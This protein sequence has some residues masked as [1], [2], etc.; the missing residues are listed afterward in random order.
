MKIKILIVL[1]LS[2][3]LAQSTDIETLL[4]DLEQAEHN[5]AYIEYVYDL[6]EHPIDINKATKQ[7]LES[8]PGVSPIMAA[9]IIFYRNRHGK[10]RDLSELETLPGLED[11][12]EIISRFMKVKRTTTADLSCQG[13]H[14]IQRRIHLQKGYKDNSYAGN[15]YKFYSR[16]DGC[17]NDQIEWGLVTEK[18]PGEPKWNDHTA[19]NLTLKLNSLHSK[20]MLGDF[21]FQSAT[22][23]VFGGAFR[24]FKG[25]NPVATG[26][27]QTHLKAY[28]SSNENGYF[29]GV[30][31]ESHYKFLS[32][33][34][35]Q[36]RT[37]KDGQ[38]ED[39]IIISMPTTG[40][41]R[42][43]TERDRRH[44][45]NE[46]VWGG[47][48]SIHAFQN[49]EIGVTFQHHKLPCAKYRENDIAHLFKN[50]TPT[51]QVASIHTNII[52][53]DKSLFGEIA[54]SRSGGIAAFGGVCYEGPRI[55]TLFSVRY[56]EPDYD[57]KFANSLAEFSHI[58]NEKGIYWGF[59]I[60]SSPGTSISAYIDSYQEL[61]PSSSASFPRKGNEFCM[62]WDQEFSDQ[63][64]THFRY[65]RKQRQ[66]PFN[67]VDKF[68]N[69]VKDAAVH[70]QH[71]ARL[72]VD[73]KRA[74]IRFRTRL[75]VHW[76]HLQNNADHPAPV[77]DSTSTLLY[78]DMRIKCTSF[79]NLYTRWTVFDAP[80]Y[81]LRLYQFEN[82]LPGTMSIKM[83]NNRGTR[84]Y[85]LLVLKFK[86]FRFSCKYS[87]T[88][89][90]NKN[91][92]GSGHNLICSSCDNSFAAQFQ[93]RF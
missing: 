82:S 20:L 16:F 24:I 38:I 6:M 89:Y 59:R 47:S 30:A 17:I 76:N 52:L 85:V 23:L 91:S 93:W 45:I 31:F 86:H 40:Y 53:N 43:R 56:Y 3:L 10:I 36:S 50:T 32:V 75:E 66:E 39:S 33:S 2:R 69:P 8:L 29:R 74:P 87:H 26:H 35:F 1:F 64:S 67:S 48:I 42:T 77:P 68:G 37:V 81:P 11:K 78:E 49:S 12:Y 72:Q 25:G 54:Q 14:R 71:Q 5:S 19:A 51:N 7:E 44:Q 83:L 18:D 13:R 9:R 4:G 63:V 15:P 70:L 21:S 60:Q 92:F 22:G 62:Q 88:L 57:N 34:G 28:L 41:H 80:I 79:L 61:W 58:E 73:I 90:D 27:P 55:E 65:K 46:T 84:W